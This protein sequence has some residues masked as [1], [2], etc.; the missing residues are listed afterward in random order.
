MLVGT[1]DKTLKAGVT[2]RVRQ[3]E[4]YVKIYDFLRV[5]WGEVLVQWKIKLEL[6]TDHH[7]FA[8]NCL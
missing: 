2:Q 3:S 6:K 8:V 5:F 4:C 1:E 7:F